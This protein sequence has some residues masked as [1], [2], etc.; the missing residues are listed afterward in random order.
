MPPSSEACADALSRPAG[1]PPQTE[2]WHP[3]IR[4]FKV[5]SGAQTLG[6]MVTHLG[7]ESLPLDR[8]RRLARD[9]VD[10]AVDPLDRVDD[11]CRG[12]G[13]D[14]VRQ[15]GPVGRHEVVGLDG[16]EGDDV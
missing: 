7:R 1:M 4:S 14:V 5:T 2:A 6:T 12:A 13:E 10:D 15:S 9:V 3:A 8:P 11:P 16:A